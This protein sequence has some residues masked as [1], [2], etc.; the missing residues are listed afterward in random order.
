MCFSLLILALAGLA[1]IAE[2]NSKDFH[3]FKQVSVH[4][5][6]PKKPH[7]KV[8]HSKGKNDLHID[9]LNLK[10]EEDQH[11]LFDLGLLLNY[12]LLPQKYFQKYHRQVRKWT[13]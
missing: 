6:D 9:G 10:I 11:L 2:A 12:D 13:Y 5:L 8:E 7:Q 1:I 4:L 3:T